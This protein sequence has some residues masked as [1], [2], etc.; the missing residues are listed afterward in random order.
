M[1]VEWRKNKLPHRIE[2]TDCVPTRTKPGVVVKCRFW[3]QIDDSSCP[4]AANTKLASWSPVAKT[5][6]DT[7]DLESN[8]CPIVPCILTATYYKAQ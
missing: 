1:L 5:S 2:N 3:E 8:Y 7:A 4:Q 6:A